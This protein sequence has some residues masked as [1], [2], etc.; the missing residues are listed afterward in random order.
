MSCRVTVQR[1][2]PDRVVIALGH[3]VF[4]GI[5][6]AADALEAGISL[7]TATSDIRRLVEAGLVTQRGRAGSTRDTATDGLRRIATA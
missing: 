7:A 5:A 4:S 1:G 6:R 3:S 2:W